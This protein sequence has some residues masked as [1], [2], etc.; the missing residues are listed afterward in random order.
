M[1]TTVREALGAGVALVGCLVWTPGGAASFGATVLSD[2]GN[3][4]SSNCAPYL[5]LLTVPI[6][7]SAPSRVFAAVTASAPARF[8]DPPTNTVGV[9]VVAVDGS[10]GVRG[11]I[12]TATSSDQTPNYAEQAILHEGSMPWDTGAAA[13]ELAPGDYTLQ[14]R[15]LVRYN[16]S[17][18]FQYG[19]VTLTCM[20]LS[21]HFDEIFANG[22]A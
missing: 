8:A 15:F 18:G 7:V 16:T 1:G 11:T 5:T 20:L 10:G 2:G 13:M 4:G 19:P 3:A 22:F 17:C 21:A 14:V 6:T 12:P 9:S